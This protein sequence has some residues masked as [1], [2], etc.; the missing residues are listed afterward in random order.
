M[1]SVFY[2]GGKPEL[3]V[4]CLG[5]DTVSCVIG[6]HQLDGPNCFSAAS[7]NSFSHEKCLKQF[8]VFLLRVYLW[9]QVYLFQMKIQ[10]LSPW[11]SRIGMLNNP[12]HVSACFVLQNKYI[13]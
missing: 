9:L 7:D 2:T 6:S 11:V 12:F 13:T 10:F 5:S 8:R 4:L 1:Y 3:E